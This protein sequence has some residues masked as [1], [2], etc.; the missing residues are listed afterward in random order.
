MR[1][2]EA[3][4]AW[5]ATSHQ[6]TGSCASLRLDCTY[7]DIDEL[8]SLSNTLNLFRRNILRWSGDCHGLVRP[9]IGGPPLDRPG[10]ASC[11]SLHVRMPELGSWIDLRRLFR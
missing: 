11:A 9:V 4:S 1:V 2:P 8:S 10:I 6:A 3:H 5:L 7:F